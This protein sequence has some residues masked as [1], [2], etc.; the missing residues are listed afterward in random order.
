MKFV[1]FWPILINIC[2]YVYK[3]IRVCMDLVLNRKGGK[4]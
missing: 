2:T 3:Y 1:N 4:I